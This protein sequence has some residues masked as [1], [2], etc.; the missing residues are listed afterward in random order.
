MIPFDRWTQVKALFAAAVE[1]P[2]EERTAFLTAACPDDAPVRQEVEALLC[3]DAQAASFIEIPAIVVPTS[4]TPSAMSSGTDVPSLR[5]G[6]GL[7]PYEIVSFIGAGG[8]GEVYK[9]R[10]VRLGRHVAMKVVVDCGGHSQAVLERFN[11]EARSASAL[12]HPNIVTIYD[13]GHALIGEKSVA[14]IAM[15]LVE[16]CT[17]RSLLAEGAV[18]TERL[19]DFSVQIADAL[20]AAHGKGIV[21]R[22]LKPENIMVS[23]EGRAKILD[24]GLARV[25]VAGSLGPQLIRIATADQVTQA[26]A[27]VGTAAYMSPQQANGQTVDFRS[28]QFS[29]GTILY[30]MATG[31]RTFQRATEMETLAAITGV[32][33][34]PI[35]HVA[36]ELPAP[37]QWIVTRCLAK[38]PEDRYASTEELA[39][40]LAIVRQHI[41]RPHPAGAAVPNVHNL[42]AQRTSLVGRDDELSA[43]RE[44]LLRPDVRL[45]TLTGPG[46]CGKT[47]LAIQLAADLVERFSGGVYFVGLASATD[48]GMVASAL[49]Q[50]LRLP[51]SIGQPLMESVKEYARNTRR[52]PTLLLLD[53]FEQVLSAAP[54]TAELLEAWPTLKVL[55]TS[56]AALRVYGEHEFRV[57]PLALPEPR[58]LTSV[59]KLAEYP[60]VALFLQRARAATGDFASSEENV[61]AAAEICARLDGL[62]LA[63]ELAAART[64]LFSPVAMLPRLRSR[65]QL[66]ARGPRD[67]PERHRTLRHTMDWS[68]ELLSPV[69]Q[70]LFQR[71]SVFV[72]GCSLEAAEA[73]CNVKG[74][75]EVDMLEGLASLVDQSLIWRSDQSDGNVRVHMLETVREYGLERLAESGEEA[76]I[77]RAHAAYCLIVAEEAEIDLA[78]GQG[79]AAWMERLSVE[80]DNIRAALDWLTMTGHAEWGLRLCNALYLYWKSRAPAE[81][82]QRLLLLARPTAASSVPKLRAKALATAGGLAL[83]QADFAAARDLNEEA[84]TIF[85]DLED[86]SGVLVCLNNLAV[87]NREQGNYAAASSLFLEIVRLLQRI[88]D[89]TSVAHA[90]SNLA[91]VARA[92]GDYPRARSLHDECLSI[93]REV[94]D[95]AGTAWSLNHN[96]DIAREQGDVCT[97]RALY[98]QALE[99]F[100]KQNIQL[101]V[102]R[103]LVDLG[104]LAREQGDP[105]RAQS[106]FAD[107]LAAFHELGETVEVARV[108]EELAPCAVDQK[109]WDRALRLA[110]AA[111]ALRGKLGSLLPPSR[112]SRLESNLAVARHHLEP[113]PAAMAWMEGNKLPLQEVVAYAR[114]EAADVS[115]N[116]PP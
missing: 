61:R 109:C 5:P 111:S 37:F 36:P 102:A 9:A 23:R 68:H 29:F 91:D 64:K 8:M 77:R 20:A 24:F 25:E 42:P 69:E 35:G 54:Q 63:I 71:L 3:A 56:R 62:P 50:V 92:Q 95:S 26:S 90:L 40:E 112:T 10:D 33:A 87:L 14:Y 47:R 101:G 110:A 108:L 13:I 75:L 79:Q 107:A 28:D 76:L 65:L 115:A 48:S 86:S 16:G 78:A 17:L 52:R 45:V 100:R 74:D 43:I 73:V 38:N 7:G 105:R 80:G 49:A 2:P 98:E 18:P 58:S 46:G 99:L 4:S 72:G 94:G 51:H 83:D 22:D 21:H 106:L 113:T 32:D 53:N 34:E 19:L 81:G 89:R 41:E 97:A 60:A 96:A 55:V 12:N 1:C 31:R 27:V 57:P 44:L 66:L 114:G 104:G 67:A 30:E 103:C 116:P 59:D 15:E 84:L 82:R 93:F 11:R 6:D 85:R 70:K 88:G 39:H